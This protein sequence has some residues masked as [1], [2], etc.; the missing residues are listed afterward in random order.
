MNHNGLRESTEP[1]TLT[2][3]EEDKNGNG[4]LDPGEDLDG[5]LRLDTVEDRNHNGKR[6]DIREQ[7][8]Q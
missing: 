8:G 4:V 5:D 6:A 7:V 2:H 1:S 3:S